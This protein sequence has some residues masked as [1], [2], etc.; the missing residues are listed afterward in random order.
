[1][2]NEHPYEK[3]P[4]EKQWI[5]DFVRARNMEITKMKKFGKPKEEQLA[6][7]LIDHQN[8][9]L[10]MFLHTLLFTTHLSRPIDYK[11]ID[12]KDKD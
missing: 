10:K 5:A 1:M 8:K 6:K 4:K 9:I 7:D 3:I 2:I 11:D 12:E